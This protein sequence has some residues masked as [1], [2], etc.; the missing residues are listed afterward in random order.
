M[1][2]LKYLTCGPLTKPKSA[3]AKAAVIDFRCLQNLAPQNPKSLAV[4]K[5]GPVDRLI[6]L[7]DYVS[8][9]KGVLRAACLRLQQFVVDD[10]PIVL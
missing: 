8:Y 6:H 5:S 4:V 2:F 3:E 9:M 7:A 1:I 10:E